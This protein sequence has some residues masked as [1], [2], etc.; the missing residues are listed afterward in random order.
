LHADRPARRLLWKLL[1]VLWLSMMASL[2]T[3]TLYFRIFVPETRATTKHVD[4]LFGLVPIAPMVVGIVVTLLT[5]LLLAWYLSRPLNHLSWAL[6]EMS[7]GRLETRVTPLMEGRRDEIT[8]LAHDF[9]RMARQ[10]Q[11]LTESRKVLLH[12]ISHELR[13]PLGR[14]Q[15]A[16]GLLRQSPELLEEM[17]GRIER[18][19]GR[20]D[21]LIEELLT[22]HR[23]ESAPLRAAERARV[24]L[25]ELLQAIVEDADFEAHNCG[26]SVQC[27]A[28]DSFV[29]EVNGELI[30]RA[31]ENVV[32]NAVKYT[33]AGS[34]VSVHAATTPDARA[35]VVTVSDRGPGVPAQS[36]QTIFDPF[37]RVE[38][39]EQTRGVGLGLA[40]AR[41]ALL[42][43]GGDIVARPREGGGLEVEMRV[44]K[45]DAGAR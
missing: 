42:L 8:D 31:F 20:L 30:Y 4:V 25:V 29:T 41:R 7:E 44:P 22:L 9:D 15:A 18:E 6:R 1:L 38:G 17:L 16:L 26:S 27:T 3:T 35:L 43:H 2:V 13:S 14:M 45:W 5:S 32:R 21:G 19:T 36:L 34:V 12:D 11:Q 37:V 39:S 23:L 40:I 33:F 10:L 28:G 24:D